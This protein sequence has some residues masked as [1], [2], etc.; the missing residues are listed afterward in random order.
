MHQSSA[1]QMIADF[2]QR[3][4]YFEGELK[5]NLDQTPNISLL[6]AEFANFKAFTLSALKAIQHQ[7]EMNARSID[8]LEMQSRRKILLIHGVPDEQSEVTTSVVVKT[9]LDKLKLPSGIRSG[10]PNA[11]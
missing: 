8:S 11:I 3:M 4:E 7:I 9:V 1:Q 5:K 10:S 6:A 2:S